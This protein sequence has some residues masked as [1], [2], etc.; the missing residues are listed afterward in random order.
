MASA[1]KPVSGLVRGYH[2]RRITIAKAASLLAIG[3]SVAILIA[4]GAS[5][6]G[7]VSDLVL[8]EAM[9]YCMVPALVAGVAWGT[10]R[11]VRLRGVRETTPRGRKVEWLAMSALWVC[12]IVIALTTLEY[13]SYLKANNALKQ[14]DESVPVRICLTTRQFPLPRG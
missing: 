11:S 7:W 6:M 14:S 10:A 13:Y 4:V 1:K 3:L 12:L 5:G 9:R 2:D 8:R